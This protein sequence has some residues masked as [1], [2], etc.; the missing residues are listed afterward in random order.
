MSFALESFVLWVSSS[1]EASIYSFYYSKIGLFAGPSY[2]KHS[3]F[4]IYDVLSLNSYIKPI[5]LD[6]SLSYLI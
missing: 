1:N 2:S 4:D 5:K 6:N 3:A